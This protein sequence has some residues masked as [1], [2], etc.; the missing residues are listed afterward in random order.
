VHILLTV[1]A[2]ATEGDDPAECSDGLDNDSDEETDCEDSG[3]SKHPDCS[4]PRPPPDEALEPSTP[5]PSGER[6]GSDPP[7]GQETPPAAPDDDDSGP[8]P[9]PD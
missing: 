2:S 7:P 3:C 9:T 1:P 8:Q 6:G 5:E 4:E